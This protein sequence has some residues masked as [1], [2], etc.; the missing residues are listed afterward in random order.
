MDKHE[1]QEYRYVLRIRRNGGEWSVFDYYHRERWVQDDAQQLR[2]E[3]W[4]TWIEDR[5]GPQDTGGLLS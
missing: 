3:G 4:E 2:E 1:A 5:D